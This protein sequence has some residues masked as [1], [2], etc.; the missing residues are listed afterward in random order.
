MPCGSMKTR[1]GAGK[2]TTLWNAGA[3]CLAHRRNKTKFVRIIEETTKLKSCEIGN[4]HDLDF[5]YPDSESAY[6]ILQSAGADLIADPVGV[7][8]DD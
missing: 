7:A 3:L 4:F 8:M 2:R 6:S 1:R 5:M